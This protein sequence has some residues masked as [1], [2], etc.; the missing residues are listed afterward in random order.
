MVEVKNISV[1]STKITQ[2]H[3][4]GISTNTIIYIIQILRKV[5]SAHLG[6]FF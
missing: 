6:T 1:H 5:E 2:L 4:I 3:D